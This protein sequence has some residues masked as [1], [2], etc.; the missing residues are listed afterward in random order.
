MV[1]YS[2]WHQGS[3]GPL[4]LILL[5]FLG[6]LGRA[7]WGGPPEKLVKRLKQMSPQERD[8]FLQRLP[9]QQRQLFQKK[10]ESDNA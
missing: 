3:L 10:L 2:A 6:V 4:H 1:V 5:F 8:K 7:L 9:E